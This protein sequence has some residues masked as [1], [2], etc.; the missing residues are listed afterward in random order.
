MS[1]F[2]V[3]ALGFLACLIVGTVVAMVK[4]SGVHRDN[5]LWLLLWVLAGLAIA[6]PDLTAIV[7]AAL[8]IGRGAD[9]VLY[10]AV[11]VM[12]VGFLMVYV[13][14]RRLRRDLTLLVRHLALRDATATAGPISRSEESTT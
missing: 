9:L 5:L 10:C 14:L 8:G 1:T 3:L 13:R 4:R 12:M 11:V 7:A 6:W 2:Q